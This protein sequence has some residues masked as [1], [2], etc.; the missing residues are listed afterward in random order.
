MT[1]ASDNFNR[2]N[3]TPI[4]SPW[5]ASIGSG[6]NLTTN[7][8]VST[9]AAEKL[10]YYSGTWGND[11]ETSAIFGNLS[12][13]NN[14]SELVLRF[15]SG[16]NGF[17]VYTD[18]TAGA[19]HTEFASYSAGVA[20]VLGVIATAIVNGDT[21]RFTI[22]GQSPNIILTA[23]KNGT[24]IGQITGQTGKN[25]GNPGGGGFGPATVDD[26][27]ATDNAGGSTTV[28]PVG[29]L[30]TKPGRGPGRGPHHRTVVNKADLSGFGTRFR[31]P[32]IDVF[33]DASIPIPPPPPV[34]A[35]KL[36]STENRP[37][38]GPYSVG[39]FF[40]QRIDVFTETIQSI[41][42][43]GQTNET[44]TFTD[45][46][47]GQL[48]PAVSQAESI[49]FT[50][51]QTTQAVFSSSRAETVT[52][53]DSQDSN[54]LSMVFETIAL[55]DAQ[56]VQAVFSPSSAE[57]I[58]LSDAQTGSAT[59]PV[60]RDETLTFSD[61]QTGLGVFSGNQAE[62]VTFTDSQDASVIAAG[63][64]TTNEIITF[65]DNQTGVSFSEAPAQLRGG[66]YDKTGS[67]DKRRKKLEAFN[68]NLDTWV[69]QVANPPVIPAPVERLALSPEPEVKI[70]EIYSRIP[71]QIAEVKR[72]ATQKQIDQD[73]ED[74][75]VVALLL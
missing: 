53:T 54:L 24:Q 66:G 33:T 59:Y 52:F 11:Q 41:A 61:A 18:G 57:S 13:G 14:Y 7:A 63:T 32:S 20:T 73:L 5:V 62:S 38:R 55:T 6:A 39:A 72:L 44:V 29:S 42:F 23:Y 8:L 37:G 65:S 50:D 48:D 15:D 58:T 70:P 71:E 34:L 47:T 2:A 46:Q 43:N 31:R 74:E 19:T 28:D 17:S 22:S 3:E 40:R 12:Q 68:K 16:G 56:T 26:W 67:E 64:N 9:T 51:G 49:T 60:Q 69:G 30:T 4:A 1:T 21:A 10:S 35:E 36:R 27:S 45:G 25:S 75:A